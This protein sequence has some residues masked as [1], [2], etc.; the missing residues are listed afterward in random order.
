S[1]RTARRA[2]PPPISPP[3]GSVSG[4]SVPRSATKGP[5]YQEGARCAAR[6]VL[7]VGSKMITRVITSSTGPTPLNPVGSEVS[8]LRGCPGRR[9]RR[10]RGTVGVKR[11]SAPRP[12]GRRSRSHGRWRR[13]TPRDRVGRQGE[14]TTRRRHAGILAFPSS[15]GVVILDR[16]RLA[17]RVAVVTGAGRGIGAAA[18]VALAE[19]GADV[20]VSARTEAELRE[21]AGRVEAAGR[22]AAVVP[23]DL[24][25]LPAAA[26]LGRAAGGAVR[27]PP[28]AG[29]NPGGARAPPV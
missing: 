26:G 23:A 15:G 27:R 2:E 29:D 10:D 1:D 22:R 24:S 8:H 11:L 3:A 13:T 17:D 14:T 25:D 18:A 7:L 20:L 9:A 19:A 21:V 28:P 6:W 4:G 5:G 16:F 12:S